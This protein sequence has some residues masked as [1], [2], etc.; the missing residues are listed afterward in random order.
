MSTIPAWA[1]PVFRS[2]EGD[3]VPAKKMVYAAIRAQVPADR[4]PSLVAATDIVAAALADRAALRRDR[5]G[6]RPHPAPDLRARVDAYIRRRFLAMCPVGYHYRLS[7]HG[8]VTVQVG[9]VADLDQ[10][11]WRDW[12]GYAKSCRYPMEGIDTTL[13]LPRGWWARVGSRGLGL[14]DGQIIL[15][16]ADGRIDPHGAVVHAA[17]VIVQGRGGHLSLGQRYVAVLP[18]GQGIGPTPRAAI[19]AARRRVP[20]S[21]T[22]AS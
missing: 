14:I 21:G 19:A 4:R 5:R 3:H 11:A 16:L 8:A 15:D 7:S 18:S 17:T 13:T 1:I 12:D 2:F 6:R 20:R 9:A 22:R 10:W